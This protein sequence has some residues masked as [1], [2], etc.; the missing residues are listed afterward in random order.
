MAI[1]SWIDELVAVAGSVK[2]HIGGQVKAYRVFKKSEIPEALSE[3][4]CAITFGFHMVP[5]YSDSSPCVDL[6]EGST[7]FHLFADDK[8]ANYPEAMRYFAKIRNAFA[9]RRRLGG[10]VEHL[11]LTDMTLV[12]AQYGL[13]N[14]HHAILV[15][16]QVKERVTAEITLGQ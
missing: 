11:T 13:E 8:K 3:F 7:E 15:T 9:F 5:T 6:W 4:P 1:E 10:L 14:E 16:W 2:S 12:M